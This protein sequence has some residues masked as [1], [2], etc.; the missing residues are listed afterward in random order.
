[1]GSSSPNFSLT[2]AIVECP[3][4]QPQRPMLAAAPYWSLLGNDSW[5]VAIDYVRLLPLEEQALFPH[6]IRHFFQ[7][8]IGLLGWQTSPSTLLCGLSECLFILNECTCDEGTYIT[9]YILQWWA[10][11]HGTYW[12]N[13]MLYYQKSVD[14]TEWW[15][16]PAKAYLWLLLLIKSYKFMVCTL[17]EQALHRTISPIARKKDLTVK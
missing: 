12:F 13:R 4:W 14:V 1:M 8:F 17:N 7:V 9:T 16:G 10:Y 15:H 3:N 5:L 6:G 11:A 2:A